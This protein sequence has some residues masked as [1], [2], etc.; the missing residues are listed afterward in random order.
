M[1]LRGSSKHFFTFA[2]P[3]C[4]LVVRGRRILKYETEMD[5]KRISRIAITAFV[6]FSAFAGAATLTTDPLTK[7][8]IIPTTSGGMIAGNDPTEISETQM[9]K[10]KMRANIYTV[11]TGKLSSTI[12]WYSARVPGFHHV[13]EY[14]VDRAQDT[15]YNNDG[16]I[17]VSITGERGKIGE[18]VN[19]GSVVYAR[20]LPGLSEKEIV[21]LNASH[22]VCE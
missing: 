6:G 10:S 20:I 9:C 22:L 16:T 2:R 12:A 14:G 13:H 11:M 3:K 7:L 19:T 18:D 4:A 21:S 5:L 1:Q 17:A 15:F 8:P